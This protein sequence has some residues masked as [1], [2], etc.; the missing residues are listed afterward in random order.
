MRLSG[1]LNKLAGHAT[2]RTKDRLRKFGKNISKTA[3]AV[4]GGMKAS[5]KRK[6]NN[7]GRGVVAAAETAM[8]PSA[9]PPPT[10]GTGTGAADSATPPTPSTLGGSLGFSAGRGAPINRRKAVT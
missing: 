2:R 5:P 3:K 6:A 9:T 8:P 1:G 4:S 10:V 7:R